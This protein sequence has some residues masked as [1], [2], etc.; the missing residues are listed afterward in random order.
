MGLKKP[1]TFSEQIDRLKQHGIIIKDEKEAKTILSTGNYY[2]LSGYLLQYRKSI[3]D[4][5]LK[6]NVSLSS[7]Y[8]IYKFD[9][10]IRALLRIFLEK[11]GIYFRTQISYYFTLSKCVSSP[12]DQHYDRNNYF[13]KI[14]F[15]EVINTF[16]KQKKFYKDSPVLRHHQIVYQNKMPLWVIVEFL[17]FSNLSKLYNSMYYSEKDIIA[18]SSGTGRETLEN[19]LHC[20]TVLRNK[21]AHSAR[22]YNT[23]FNPPAKFPKK[24]LKNNPL[25][26]NDTLFAYI[27]VLLKRLPLKEDKNEL[28]DKIDFLLNKYKGSIDL[29]LIG[30]PSNYQTLFNNEIK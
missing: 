13:D 8:S 17:S 26:K 25:V 20:L 28:A 6:E 24:F 23:N 16:K 19:H 18:T 14:G 27:L 10:E 15:D 30:F 12:H 7:I 1:L 2:R 3:T 22:L 21:C 29:L 11:V 4:S 5:D 9:E